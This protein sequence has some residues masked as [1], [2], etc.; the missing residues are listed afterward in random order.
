ML[1]NF[2]MEVETAA[3]AHKE[4][5][6]IEAIDV[7][8]NDEDL[9]EGEITDDEEE[10]SEA[11]AAAEAAERE[12]AEKASED[13][14]KDKENKDS[15]KSRSSRRDKS[16]DRKSSRLKKE[17]DAEEEKKRLLKE[18]L[19]QLERQMADDDDEDFD[20]DEDEDEDGFPSRKRRSSSSDKSRSRSPKR[21]RR[22]RSRDRSRRHDKRDHRSRRDR[23]KEDKKDRDV[24]K[25]FML[26][27]CP[28]SPERCPFSHDCEPPKIMELCKFYLLERC[29]KKEKCLYL[30][31]GFPCKYF[32]TGH[33]CLDTAE[34]CKF[35]HD[36]LSDIT[37]NI[38]LKHLEAAPKEILG[39][40]PRLTREAAQALVFQTEAKNKGWLE[41]EP[42][43]AE[44]IQKSVGD[45]VIEEAK[46]QIPRKS[47]WGEPVAPT[48]TA[49]TS[50]PGA[51]FEKP[52]AEA[53]GP[54]GAPQGSNIPN[55]AILEGGPPLDNGLKNPGLGLL[56]P[57]P[58]DLRPIMPPGPGGPGGPP[59]GPNGQFGPNG[60]GPRPGF[61]QN[62]DQGP[63]GP[64]PT[65]FQ[66]NSG[67]PNFP[68]GYGDLGCNEDIIRSFIRENLNGQ[69]NFRGGIDGTPKQGPPDMPP[70]H[71]H[72]NDDFHPDHDRDD[73]HR[74]PHGFHPNDGPPMGGFHR[75][76][77][78]PPF[79]RNDGPPFRR[80][81]GPPRDF[82]GRDDFFPRDDFG[83]PHNDPGFHHPMHPRGDMPPP[84]R[85]HPG[86]HR[87]PH[88]GPPGPGGHMG[89]PHGPMGGHPGGP[90]G[91]PPGGPMG[92]PMGGPPHPFG[93]P[94][95]QQPPPAFN[96]HPNNGHHPDMRPDFNGPPLGPPFRNNLQDPPMKGSTT[97]TEEDNEWN[98]GPPNPN[99]GGPDRS[100]TRTRAPRRDPRRDPRR[101]DSAESGPNQQAVMKD[102]E[103]I[104]KEKEKRMLEVDLSMFGDLELPGIN[105]D[106][107][108]EVEE[109]NELGLPFKPH[110]PNAIAKE[111]DAS[112]NSHSPLEYRL[113]K[114]TLEKPDYSGL[115]AKQHIPMSRIQLDPRLRRYANDKKPATSVSSASTKESSPT[116]SSSG[117]RDDPRLKKSSNNSSKAPKVPQTGSSD[118]GV[119]N[120]SRDLF[121]PNQQRKS[122][123]QQP[124]R[125]VYSP[126][127]D[128]QD[129]YRPP[130]GEQP[131]SDSYNP[132]NDLRSNTNP[133][134]FYQ[135][136][137][138][139]S[140]RSDPRTNRRD[141]RRR[142]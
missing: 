92:G 83:P 14:D 118:E 121:R 42:K 1:L 4:L 128:V 56:G 102:D 70:Q 46:K 71:H 93:P 106:K 66:Q 38:L 94:R 32:H 67:R 21:R 20:D 132:M 130:P 50:T 142:D 88:G 58:P 96:N 100:P 40:F 9:E 116:I 29:A 68:P 34:S 138:S 113:R 112:I 104:E 65:P 129:L 139:A 74:P 81:D 27:K 90:M 134:A 115:I 61:P 79:R 7:D 10:V 87:G 31:K 53:D 82:R 89:G 41:E 105:D 3:G 120:P 16:R 63:D 127:Q 52:E 114:I 49:P 57:P 37:R 30:H 18:K 140:S 109:D 84:D 122:E 15:K 136:E 2:E 137:A 25:A 107:E 131:N 125:D 5:E 135:P 24:C 48:A 141:P 73:M 111:I 64:N 99:A 51:P 124:I 35:S 133:Q 23:D 62:G 110:I 28:K 55:P 117:P 97:P 11:A 80:D 119:Y 19:R 126:T 33:R 8:A 91:G 98:N 54:F 77:D 44:E 86:H 43:S 13:V 75:D 69:N 78:G 85:F 76:Q 101:Q 72:P 39:D 103:S 36:D 12:A 22:S 17:L 60:P 59:G 45:A 123:A 26:G 47:R 95:F 6:K 108:E